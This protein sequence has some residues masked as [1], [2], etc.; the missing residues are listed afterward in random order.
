MILPFQVVGKCQKKTNVKMIQ[1]F[2][3]SI[4]YPS[5][6]KYWVCALDNQSSKS[7]GSL[8]EKKSCMYFK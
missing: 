8:T 7:K 4:H 6:S 1:F 5:D 2:L 3:L